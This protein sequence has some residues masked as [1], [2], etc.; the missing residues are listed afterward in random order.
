M[1]ERP[2]LV[3]EFYEVHKSFGTKQR[4]GRSLVQ[5]AAR[6]RP[7]VVLGGSGRESP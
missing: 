2:D 5:G 7:I 3:V 1:N 4:A 6:R